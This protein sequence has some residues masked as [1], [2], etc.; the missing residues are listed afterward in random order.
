MTG[1]VAFC[2]RHELQKRLM[3]GKITAVIVGHEAASLFCDKNKEYLI[4]HSPYFL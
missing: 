2:V 4:R 3:Y 1:R